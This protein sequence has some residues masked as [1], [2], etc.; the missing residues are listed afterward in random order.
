[1]SRKTHFIS[2][3]HRMEVLDRNLYSTTGYLVW[4]LSWSSSAHFQENIG[5]IVLN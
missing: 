2:P 1:M 3:W 4:D 5:D